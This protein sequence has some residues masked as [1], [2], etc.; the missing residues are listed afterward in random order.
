MT[1]KA[2]KARRS[3]HKDARQAPTADGP[4]NKA[5]RKRTN[6]PWE[7]V[8]LN[9]FFAGVVFHRASTRE[10]AEA[11]AEKQARSYASGEAR[12]EVLLRPNP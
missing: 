3:K 6:K 2:A 5:R 1:S 10:L 11:W 9:G 12:F 4:C 8:K 7:V